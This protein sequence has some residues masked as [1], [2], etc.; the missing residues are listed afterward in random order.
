MSYCSAV[1]IF[2]PE[3]IGDYIV[4]SLFRPTNSK[5]IFNL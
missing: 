2:K 3:V 1:H 4:R 5:F